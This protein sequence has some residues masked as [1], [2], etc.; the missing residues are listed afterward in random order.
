MER[1]KHKK[2]S[3]NHY[4]DNKRFYDEIIVYRKE[5]KK[6]KQEGREEPRIPEYVGECIFKIAKKLSYKPCFI[7]YSFRD[8]MISDGIENSLLYFHDYDPKKGQNP[9]A[10]FT[11]IIYYAFLRR[12]NK[13][14]KN[15]YIV[16][17]NF[18]HFFSLFDHE[19]KSLLSENLYANI[20][21]FM[22]RFEKKEELRKNKRKMSKGLAKFIEE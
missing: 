6:A 16:Y 19:E 1:K 7:N 15:R 10:Y 22:H 21:D 13:E 2:T 17:K 14:E 4:V 20:N 5:L 3:N 9:F 12:I 11:Q 8:E 18:Q